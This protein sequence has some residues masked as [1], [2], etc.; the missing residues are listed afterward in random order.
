MK[1][2]LLAS[3][4]ALSL[5][6]LAACGDKEEKVEEVE[7]TQVDYS[8]AVSAYKSEVMPLLTNFVEDATLL[9][10][11]INAGDLESATKLYPI[12]HMYV[13]TLRPV[14]S[15]FEE[16]YTQVDAPTTAGKELDQGGLHAIEYA[17][18]AKQDT[19]LA[20]APAADLVA[21]VTAFTEQLAKA[22]LD[23]EAMLNATNDAL[24]VIVS[25]TLT[26]KEV[27]LSNAQAYDLAATL[28]GVQ[29]VKNS[30]AS[31]ATDEAAKNLD[32]AFNKAS[33]AVA[34]YEVGKEDYVNFSY[35]TNTQKQELIDVFT[36]LQEAYK[37]FVQSMK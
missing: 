33:E 29:M 1:K 10:T 30:F 3:M 17:L 32:E 25:D 16:F 12:V 35:F 34:F 15:Q 5:M 20:T 21:N 6:T 24:N 27:N 37:A 23:G 11:Q 31:L 26:G 2:L 4:T 9:Q 8:E 36:E 19:T 28:Q 18:M 13:E 14:A 7:V 22:N